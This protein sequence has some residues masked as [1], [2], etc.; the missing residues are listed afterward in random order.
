MAN[1]NDMGSP[2]ANKAE[3]NR[4]QKEIAVNNSRIN[5]F[6][7]QIGEIY[8]KKYG[9]NPE[10]EFADSVKVIRNSLKE[11]AEAEKTIRDIRGVAL[12]ENC[13]KEFPKGYAFCPNCGSAAPKQ[14]IP[15]DNRKR[16]VTC[17]EVVAE[18]LNF[19]A[20]CGTP[21]NA[22]VP[23]VA[24]APVTDEVAPAPAEETPVAAQIPVVDE[25]PVAD[26]T[27]VIEEAPVADE[28]PVIE[29][30]PA[31]NSFIFC[32]TCGAKLDADSIFCENCGAR[33]NAEPDFPVTE[34]PASYE[35]APAEETPVAD[36]MPVADET[37]AIE[38]APAENCFIFCETCGAKL[39]ADSFFCENCGAKV[40]S[41][42]PTPIVTARPA[43]CEKCGARLA[44]NTAFCEKCGARV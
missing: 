21:I 42:E 10:E 20:N 24:K 9:D 23:S 19:C 22:P 44:D 25:M 33:V 2:A 40:P 38:E 31:A 18:G 7:I 5:Q 17:G 28:T 30:A 29:E 43:F 15:A 6:Y 4:L 39:D 16:C 1:Y 32:E 27:P 3:I 37:P 13:L 34:A 41:A 35:A 12:C 11:N 14:E 26:E 8:L 36:E